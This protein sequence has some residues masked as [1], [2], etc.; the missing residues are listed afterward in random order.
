MKGE[1]SEK[2]RRRKRQ[3][4]P[5]FGKKDARGSI[6]N[7]PSNWSLLRDG[8]VMAHRLTQP[9][10]SEMAGVAQSVGNGSA[11]TEKKVQEKG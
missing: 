3:W 11:A 2:Q 9:Q 4:R 7:D 10:W 1:N 8:E 5:D 6:V